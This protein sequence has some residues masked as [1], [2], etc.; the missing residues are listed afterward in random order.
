VQV[1]HRTV[2]GVP[3]P[4][5]ALDFINPEGRLK[6]HCCKECTGLETQITRGYLK[7]FPQGVRVGILLGSLSLQVKAQEG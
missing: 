5:E 7:V 2:Q 4:I 1:K 6:D 3:R